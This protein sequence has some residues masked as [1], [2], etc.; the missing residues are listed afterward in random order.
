MGE[1]IGIVF[2]GN[3]RTAVC[4]AIVCVVL[5]T[6]FN[7]LIVKQKHIHYTIRQL[8][9][10]NPLKAVLESILI[11]IYGFGRCSDREIS[12][13]LLMLDIDDSDYYYNLRLLVVQIVLSRAVTV[14]ALLVKVH[15]FVNKNQK[16]SQFLKEYFKQKFSK[17]LSL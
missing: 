10:L 9:A 11:T 4:V 13:P 1:T 17:N 2:A 3:Q 6:V 5:M 14:F 16:T 8:V 12:L 15:P 7:N